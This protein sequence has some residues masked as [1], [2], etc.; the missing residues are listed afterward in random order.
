MHPCKGLLCIM[1]QFSFNCSF[2][3]SS[4]SGFVKDPEIRSTLEIVW[5]CT[6]IIILSTWSVL[7]LTVP[8]DLCPRG[9]RQ[10]FRK[11]VYLLGRK[12]AWMGIML[13]FPEY[14]NLARE[15]DVPWTL[16]HTVLANIGG[17][18]LR[19]SPPKTR[20]ALSLALSKSQTSYLHDL[21]DIPWKPF[22]RHVALANAA[23]PNV[24]NVLTNEK[25]YERNHIAP[26]HGNV[27]VLDSKQ[28]AIARAHGVI[29]RLPH[30]T[31]NEI[32]DRSK[33]DGLF[34]LFSLLQVLWLVAQLI[35]QDIGVPFYIDTDAIVS[36]AVFGLI[37][38]AAP[39]SF[40]QP[41]RYYISQSVV[42]QVFEDRY[43]KRHVDWM[44]I[45]TSI[46]S[47]MLFGG[48][49]LLAW[50]LSFP[51][52]IERSLWRG[53]ALTVAIA[54]TIS[55]LLVLLESIIADRT[56]RWSKWSV[57]VLGPLYLS[58]RVFIMVESYRSLYFLPPEAF[59]STWAGNVPHVG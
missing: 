28:L 53:S 23:R 9:K 41:R 45:A 1:L 59:I 42:H 30:L 11:H 43:K 18:A 51:S 56:D 10:K 48:L 7:H 44:V 54:P 6:S 25:Q 26:L 20:A 31:E 2:P 8:P 55:A 5:S 35:P 22:D 58:A 39:I 15:D 21:G 32:T 29:D 47:I 36:P 40:L 24:A 27:W 33:T 37:A 14:L 50:N 4:P 46:L 12:L 34:R 52:S 38:E 16:T 3:S 17:I 13:A 57:T 49:H 19:F